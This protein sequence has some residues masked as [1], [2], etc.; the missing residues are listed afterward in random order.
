LTTHFV[1]ADRHQCS[2]YQGHVNFQ[3]ALFAEIPVNKEFL[4]GGGVEGLTVVRHFAGIST[5]LAGGSGRVR[6]T[7]D[8]TT[9][10]VSKV[11]IWRQQ[12]A[13][14]LPPLVEL[15]D[16]LDSWKEEIATM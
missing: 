6:A 11:C 14:S 15:G 7:G 5:V 4:F 16:T 3:A 2:F 9:A 8:A 10:T 1:L 12:E 13:A